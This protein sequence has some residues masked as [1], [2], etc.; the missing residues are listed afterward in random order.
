MSS[1]EDRSEEME[2]QNSQSGKDVSSVT[3]R[4]KDQLRQTFVRSDEAAAGP[5]L[6][7]RMDS[8]AVL[9]LFQTVI[10]VR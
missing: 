9:R 4:L 3:G 6:R 7:K 5:G 1:K 10:N 8:T 2:K